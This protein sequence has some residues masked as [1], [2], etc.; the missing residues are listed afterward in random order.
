MVP[1]EIMEMPT[2]EVMDAEM[3]EETDVVMEEEMGMVE[4]MEEH[5]PVKEDGS[6]TQG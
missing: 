6:L 2:V 1:T 3:A 5:Q 4:I